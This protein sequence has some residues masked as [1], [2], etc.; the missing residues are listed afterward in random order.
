MRSLLFINALSGNLDGVQYNVKALM[1]VIAQWL[2]IPLSA[3]QQAWVEID[4]TQ[5]KEM[6]PPESTQASTLPSIAETLRELLNIMK[7]APQ[8]TLQ[9]IHAVL[10]VPAIG[11]VAALHAAHKQATDMTDRSNAAVIVVWQDEGSDE[12]QIF[13][14]I[15][16][17]ENDEIFR[18]ALRLTKSL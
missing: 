10:V 2:A 16:E 15:P 8:V 6:Y 17:P 13:H 11:H 12:P 4:M 5:V 3:V 14:V 1:R 9:E 7:L 18:E